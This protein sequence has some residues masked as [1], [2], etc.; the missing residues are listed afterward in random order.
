[1]N[2]LQFLPAY[3]REEP[4]KATNTESEVVSVKEEYGIAHI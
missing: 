4:L 3:P 2:G 1:M